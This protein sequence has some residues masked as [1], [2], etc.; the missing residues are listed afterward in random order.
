MAGRM[1]KLN[2][3]RAATRGRMEMKHNG[4]MRG[5]SAPTGERVRMT[6]VMKNILH[7]AFSI[8]AFFQ[9]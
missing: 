1:E 7:V 2:N 9:Q 5:P 8:F 6:M 4:T 3:A